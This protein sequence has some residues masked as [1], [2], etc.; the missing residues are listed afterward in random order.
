MAK[1]YPWGGFRNGCIPPALLTTV[2]G[3]LF[4]REAAG[5]LVELEAAFQ[6]HFGKP[7]IILQG[8]RALGKSSDQPGT[9]TQWGLYNE[10][11]HTDPLRAS[12]P[13]A[14]PHGYA[15]SADFASG[16]D[17][18]GSQEKD[19]MDAHAPAYGWHPT[20][21][22]FPR[23]EAWHFDYIPGTAT[24][25][26]HAAAST[27][28]E[29]DLN[30]DQDNKLTQIFD[31]IFSGGE[32]MPDQHHSIGRSLADIRAIVA[33]PVTGRDRGDGKGPVNI[34]QIQ[35]NADTNTLVRSLLAQVGA[36]KSTVATIAESSGADPK[37]IEAAAEAGAAKALSGLRLVSVGEP[38]APAPVT[39]PAPAAQ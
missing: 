2:R 16:I 22:S 18:F 24:A 1:T 23:R 8:Y 14:S 13:G 28:A 11:R 27:P 35:D 9:P 33:Q 20:G 3:E 34:S 25:T 37:A 5:Y 29:D 21:N 26:A 32:S 30:A 17:Q 7:A 12:Y 15:R 38:E 19:W 39:P 36:L 4:E 10:Y 6:A 31:A